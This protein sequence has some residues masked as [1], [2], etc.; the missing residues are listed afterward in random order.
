V[1]GELQFGKARVVPTDGFAYVHDGDDPKKPVT[2][3]MLA[4]FPI[5]RAAAV[6]AIDPESA[7]ADQVNARG[8]GS[9]LVVTQSAPDECAVGGFLAATGGQIGVHGKLQPPKPAS[10]RVTGACATTAPTKLFDNTYEFHLAYD[11]ALTPV[12]GTM[13][14]PPGGGEPGA[15]YMALLRAIA[16]ADW[17][18]AKVLLPPADMPMAEPKPADQKAFFAAVASNYPHAVKVADGVLKPERAL[19]HIT[20]LDRDGKKVRGNV[21]LKLEAGKWRVTE[22][23]IFFVD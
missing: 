3:V 19:L 18:T 11:L 12:P 6:A 16:A 7:L 17:P 15:A 9:Y 2:V 1:S 20:G 10:G 13:A 5:D 22:Q 8:A 23:S 21:A 14:A 4:D